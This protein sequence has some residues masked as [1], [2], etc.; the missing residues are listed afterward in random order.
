MAEYD[1]HFLN[2]PRDDSSELAQDWKLVYSHISKQ[3]PS[4]TAGG[5]LATLVRDRAKRYRDRRNG[6]DALSRLERK[7][8]VL[9]ELLAPFQDCDNPPQFT[10]DE[11]LEILQ[12]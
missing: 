3:L 1:R 9:I 10:P 12:R 11:I 6:D 8:D 2:V 5:V 4:P 7:I